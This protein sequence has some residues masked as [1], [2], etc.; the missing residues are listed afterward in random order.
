M[1]HYVFK[2]VLVL[3]LLG[4]CSVHPKLYSGPDLPDHE[5]VHLVVR[6][7]GLGGIPPA[8]ILAVDGKDV[9]TNL[10]YPIF[11]LKA[12]SHRINTVDRI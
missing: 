5:V 6:P 9:K 7:V 10:A 4:G 8:R 1:W 2:M 3:L 11:R 12:G